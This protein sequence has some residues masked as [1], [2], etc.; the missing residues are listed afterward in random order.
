MSPDLIVSALGDQEY[1]TIGAAILAATPEDRI[2]V[3]PGVYSEQVLIDK[4]LEIFGDGPAK[5]I[6]LTNKNSPVVQMLTTQAKIKGITVKGLLNSNKK[7]SSSKANPLYNIFS[8]PPD[9]SNL[10][11]N[12][13]LQK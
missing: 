5:N 12:N 3:R 9:N 6:V 13:A 7:T 4:P 11:L 1:K 10:L 2:L 8:K